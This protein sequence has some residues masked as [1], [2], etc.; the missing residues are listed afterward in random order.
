MAE[1]LFSGFFPAKVPRGQIFA[2]SIFMLG[3]RKECSPDPEDFYPRKF[4]TEPPL[5]GKIKP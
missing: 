1:K 3:T 4:V 2:L 5:G